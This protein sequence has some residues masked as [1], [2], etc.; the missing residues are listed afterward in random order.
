MAGLSLRQLLVGR[1]RLERRIAIG[2]MG[3]VWQAT[4]TRLDRQVAVKV[5]KPEFSGDAEFRRRFHAEARMTASLNHPGIA[6]VHDYG[7][8]TS[9][10]DSWAYIVMEL[11]AGEPL[12]TTL[13][14]HSRLSTDRTLDI[15]EQAGHALQAAHERGV[16][17]RDIKPANILITPSGTV[18]ITDFGIARAVDAAPTTRNGM[19]IGTAHYIAPEQATGK[20][21]GPASD[22]YSLAVVA[23]ECLSGQRPFPGDNALSVAMMH[24]RNPPPPLPADV[25]PQVR[26]LIEAALVKDPRERYRCG[27]EFA[28]AAAAARAG[29]SPLPSLPTQRSRPTPTAL[30][31]LASPPQPTR[32]GAGRIAIALLGAL[33][34]VL[35]GYLARDAL[36]SPTTASGA[37]T[38]TASTGGVSAPAPSAPATTPDP[39]AV[40]PTRAAPDPDQN[41]QDGPVPQVFIIPSDYL[42]HRGN[43]AAITA[44][45]HGLIPR[46]VDDDGDQIDRDQ[47]SRC[48]ITDVDSTGYVPRGSTLELTCR[49][50]R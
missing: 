23:Y 12:A 26:R 28:T 10:P 24:I 46:L 19:I 25:P 34:L 37:S 20:E 32:R 6:A 18:K 3:E 21:T 22:V 13:S 15:L 50:G 11:V 27:G 41:P 29:Q 43:D 17:H 1:Y 14:R 44:A 40:D 8:T 16:V 7:E 48:R 35:A 45:A 30:L 47:R 2:G 9:E 39:F 4:D 5:L 42:G 33:I 38:A 31:P 49:R 36:R